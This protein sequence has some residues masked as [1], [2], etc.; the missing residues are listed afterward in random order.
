MRGC[1]KDWMLTFLIQQFT[2]LYAA[3]AYI[4]NW[5]YVRAQLLGMVAYVMHHVVAAHLF[6][7]VR[8]RREDGEES[9]FVIG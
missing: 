3:V 2:W 5:N 4:C 1:E 6:T 7:R 9:V 8:G